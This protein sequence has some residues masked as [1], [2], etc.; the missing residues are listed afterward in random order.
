MERF[1]SL[2]CQLELKIRP[3]V[4]LTISIWNNMK[5]LFQFLILRRESKNHFRGGREEKCA[6]E[7]ERDR[8]GEW[9]RFDTFYWYIILDFRRDED[10]K[11]RLSMKNEKNVKLPNIWIF[12]NWNFFEIFFFFSFFFVM[13]IFSS[14]KNVEDCI[15]CNLKL[16]LNLSTCKFLLNYE[17]SLLWYFCSE[18]FLSKIFRKISDFYK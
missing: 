17:I 16:K 14:K 11:G 9:R 13:R 8:D 6:I 3:S 12:E 1:C 5:Y 10:G 18:K 2:N 15:F 7:K 4:R